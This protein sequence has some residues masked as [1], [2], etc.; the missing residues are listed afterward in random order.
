MESELYYRVNS[1][2]DGR[3]GRSV[4]SWY[5]L[6][7][8]KWIGL[9]TPKLSEGSL[10]RSLHGC[11]VKAGLQTGFPSFISLVCDQA[12]GIMTI[13]SSSRVV[14]LFMNISARLEQKMK[15]SA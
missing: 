7:L 4:S 12:A 2:P 10:L 3:K 1:S 5:L 13:A 6:P 9:P 11:P 14:I 8:I 15:S